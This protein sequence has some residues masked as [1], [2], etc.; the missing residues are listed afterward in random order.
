MKTLIGVIQSEA[1][2]YCQSE[3][4][5][6][7]KKIEGNFDVLI[8][9][10]SYDDDNFNNL[11]SMFINNTVNAIILKG[12]YINIIKDRIIENRNIVLNW[13]REHKEYDNLIFLDSDI[14]PPKEALNQLLSRK[15]KIIGTVCWIVGSAHSYRAAW[16]FFKSDVESGKHL[17]FVEHLNQNE[18]KLNEVGELIEIKETG[19]GCTFFDGEILRKESDLL[20]RDTG[21]DLKE[22][23][24]L[25][26][27]LRDR[28]YKAYI[29]MKI[30]CF[31]NLTKFGIN[32]VNQNG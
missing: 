26:R 31:H 4:L 10:N 20:F 16:N 25:I 15:E 3:W 8:V 14:F 22:D 13:F 12:P 29:D 30:S 9:E 28:G 6:N 1:N 18:T 27:D 21:F 19:L 24:T 5:E 2:V 11:K 32:E 23:F 17:D 7:L